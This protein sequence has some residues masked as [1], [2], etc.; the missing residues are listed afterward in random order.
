V[1]V[2]RPA[3]HRQYRCC[4]RLAAQELSGNIWDHYSDNPRKKKKKGV[5]AVAEQMNTL[6]TDTLL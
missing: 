1:R 4:T 2:S 3:E 5:T 6:E